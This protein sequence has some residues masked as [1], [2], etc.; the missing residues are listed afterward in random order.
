MYLMLEVAA[1]MQ[2]WEVV[3]LDGVSLGFESS[4]LG[5]GAGSW[6]LARE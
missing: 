1:G 4:E 2:N 6:E 5:A 3:E